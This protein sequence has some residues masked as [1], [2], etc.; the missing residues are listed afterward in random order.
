[1][2]RSGDSMNSPI[3]ILWIDDDETH[4][5]DSKNMMFEQKN[6]LIELIHPT[7]FEE[8]FDKY[9]KGTIDLFLIDYFLNEKYSNKNK[10]YNDKGLKIAGKIKENFPDYPVY[11]VS[12]NIEEG[13]FG[14]EAQPA[15][16]CFDKILTFKE[17][18]DG[19]FML[20]WDAKYYNQIRNLPQND[21]D[22]LI[23]LLKP[24]ENSIDKLKQVLPNELRDGLG[25]KS[26]GNAIAFG[27]WVQKKILTFPGFLYN[28]LRAATH[29][30]MTENKFINKK[31]SFKKAKYTGLFS[32]TH[33]L[34]WV[35]ELD[36][37]V[38]SSPKI[39]KLKFDN[40]WELAPR[41]FNVPQEDYSKCIVCKEQYPELVGINIRNK[42]QIAPVHYR[43]SEPCRSIK[44]EIFFDEIRGYKLK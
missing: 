42:K 11:G 1:M 5:E 34:W 37:I 23:N 8:T 13:I 20:Y 36:N 12:H 32:E 40:T 35:S 18:Q 3:R 31:N 2:Y 27:R 10:K 21:V 44:R 29:L 38:F 25:T 41:I 9:K 6:F 28:N 30:G 17:V 7:E 19:A 22:A 24:P 26:E 43:C 4:I 15:N 39:L 16:N 33:D 14:Q